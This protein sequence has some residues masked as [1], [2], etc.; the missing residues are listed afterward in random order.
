MPFLP[1]E[2]GTE[3]MA[4]SSRL[5]GIELGRTEACPWIEDRVL[6]VLS[7]PA[8]VDPA[9]RELVV[10]DDRIAIGDTFETTPLIELDGGFTCNGERWPM[11]VQLAE[12]PTL[13][14]G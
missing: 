3:L 9:D 5:A 1:F 2:G 8:H 14:D 6:V 11:A 13:I 4:V 10:G 7:T 12:A